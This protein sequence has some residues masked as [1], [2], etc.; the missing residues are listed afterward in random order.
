MALQVWPQLGLLWAGIAKIEH[1]QG[2][3]AAA[4][5]AAESALRILQAVQGGGGS[6]DSGGSGQGSGQGSGDSPLLQVRQVAADAQAEL[7]MHGR[8]AAD[9]A[10]A[11]MEGRDVED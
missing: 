9:A 7:M 10:A 6:G 1:L 11:L 5:P 2:R 8:E 3:P 4:L